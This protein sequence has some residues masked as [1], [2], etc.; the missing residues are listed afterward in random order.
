MVHKRAKS[1]RDIRKRRTE[2]IRQTITNIFN[3]IKEIILRRYKERLEQRNTI[4]HR[5]K[6]TE[7]TIRKS[8]VYVRSEERRKALKQILLI[9]KA[10]RHDMERS[11]ANKEI[12][13]LQYGTE[14]ISEKIN[15]IVNYCRM[16][17]HGLRNDDYAIP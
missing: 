14:V 6:E 9:T 17:Y 2:R 12:S 7:N 3:K 8:I 16:S 15:R 1:D 4:I 10:V 13:L 5:V 11:L